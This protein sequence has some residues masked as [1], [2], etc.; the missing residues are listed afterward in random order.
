MKSLVEQGSSSNQ[1]NPM[2]QGRARLEEF[3]LGAELTWN[4][5]QSASLEAKELGE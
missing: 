4:V 2:V 5:R 1:G 3:G